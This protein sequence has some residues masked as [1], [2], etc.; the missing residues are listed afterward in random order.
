MARTDPITDDLRRDILDG[1]FP[2]GERLV[3]QRL[4]DRYGVGRAAVRQ[5]LVELAGEGLVERLPNRGASVRRL[6]IDEAIQITEARAALEAVIAGH[7]ARHATTDERA[8]LVDI[9]RRMRDA[10]GRDAG[11]EYSDLNALLHRRL[12]EMS[13]HQVAEH[14]VANLRH[15]SARQQYRLARMP[16]RPAE[17]V[18]QHAAIVAA[19]VRGDEAGAAAAMRAHLDS[20]IDVLNGW[21]AVESDNGSGAVRPTA[22]D[23]PMA[24]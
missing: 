23:L 7:A 15:R 20:V 3:E 1:V 18:E 24:R 19:V 17:S 4:T 2:P 11:G 21:A 13:R 6:G 8:E 10:V 16:G 12:C 9:E 22:T 5:A 14:L